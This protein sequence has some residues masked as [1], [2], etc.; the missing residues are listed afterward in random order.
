MAQTVVLNGVNYQIPDV[1]DAPPT[2]DWGNQLTAYLVALAT[3]YGNTSPGFLDFVNVTTSPITG[4]SGKLYLVDTSSARTINLPAPANNAYIIVKDITGSASS[5][6]ITIARN[7][8]ESID[9]V[10][11]NKTLDLDYGG[12]I[13]VSDGTDWFSVMDWSRLVTLADDQTITGDKT[14]TGIFSVTN[15]DIGAS[16][17][18]GTL[19]IYPATASMGKIQFSAADNAGDFTINIVNA[20]HA[21]ARTYTIPDAGG[22]ASFVMTAGA[23]TIAGALT[24]S[25]ALTVTPTSNQLVLGTTRTVT[26]T[27][28]TPASSSRTWTIPDIT[29]DGT[30][31]GLEGTQTFTGTKTF[32]AAVTISASSTSAL[33]I[34]T[35][36]FVVDSTNARVAIGTA[37]PT[38]GFSLT[39]NAAVQIGAGGGSSTALTQLQFAFGVGASNVYAH[40]IKTHHSTTAN[41]NRVEF[42]VATNASTET[43]VLTLNGGGQLQAPQGSV[44]APAYSFLAN[45][46][47]GMYNDG[48]NVVRISSG[49]VQAAAFDSTST[50][51]NTR[52]II[53]DVDNAAM[54]RVTVGAAD[55]G[56]SGYKVLRIAN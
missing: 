1:G 6:N 7:G 52:L 14:Y 2:V 36:A 50:S 53:Y 42:W 34:N 15:L 27:A 33:V 13:I 49:G 47:T 40:N 5:N 51:G 46:A 10:A 25:S 11:G 3:A 31:A 35:S 12:W 55:S 23:Q 39:S 29:G 48:S 41:L 56:G 21:A 20:S 45:G 30:F 54:E 32:S 17:T 19:D 38:S 26:V 28:P 8:S 18:A 44:T 37:T 9:G 4:V 24:L 43:Q 22:N 16:G